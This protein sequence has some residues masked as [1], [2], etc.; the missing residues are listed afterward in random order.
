MRRHT[1]VVC[2]AL[3]LGHPCTRAVQPAGRAPPRMWAGNGRSLRRG[4][5]L[6]GRLLE[7]GP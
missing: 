1:A 3:R 5:P 7:L 4:V 2:R 6:C